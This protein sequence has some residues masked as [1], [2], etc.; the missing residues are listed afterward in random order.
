[1]KKIILFA[2]AALLLLANAAM[3]DSIAGKV[4]VTARGGASYIFDSEFTSSGSGLLGGLEKDLEADIGWAAGGG[5]MYGITDNLAVTFDVIYFQTDFTMHEAGGPG[6]AT[7]GTGK[8]IDFALGAQW[9]FM[10]KSA[11]VPYVGAGLD[12]L[13]NKMDPNESPSA[14]ATGTSF[15]VDPTYGAHLSVGADYFFTPNIA[16]NAEIRGL[17]ST[18]GDMTYKY[19]GDSDFVAAKYNP[20][21][22]SGFVGIRFFFGGPK[23]SSQAPVGEMRKAH[24]AA[25]KVEEKIIEKGR[26]TLKVEF[27]T[28]EAIVK[29]AYYK[30]I[31]R[32]ADIMKKYPELKIVIEGHTDNMGGEKYNLNL[33]QK[34]T[35]AIKEVMVKKFKIESARITP[36]GFGY[37]KPIAD[38]ST[39][40]GRKSNRR[41]EASLE[42]T[43]KK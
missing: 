41:V 9:R 27:D 3:A 18:K 13:W 31:E 1:M 21:N 25:A 38:N 37:S 10:P 20:S 14:W 29:P 2:T 30:E 16:L 35:E 39:K 42:Y 32:V 23:E 24:E 40:E 6:E 5:L 17:Y 34:R 7:F 12:F 36:K 11:F 15:D 4:G 8:T 22:I 19:P 33:S 43:I 26:I 28:G